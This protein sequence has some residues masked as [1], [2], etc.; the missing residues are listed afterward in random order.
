MSVPNADVITKTGGL[1]RKLAWDPNGAVRKGNVAFRLLLAG[2][3]AT[4]AV[5]AY[6]YFHASDPEQIKYKA[7]KKALETYAKQK[8][9]HTPLT[10][11][12]AD[13]SDYFKSI[14][15]AAEMSTQPSG[16]PS[17][18]SETPRP[19]S[20]ES[21]PQSSGDAESGLSV[22]EIRDTPELGPTNKP[23]SITL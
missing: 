9:Q 11:L 21:M 13:A 3:T 12:P 17:K 18:V 8:T 19:M 1:M 10:V 23:I 4:S 16:K 14:A 15:E 7:Y 20:Q 22:S 2:L 6:K 5:G